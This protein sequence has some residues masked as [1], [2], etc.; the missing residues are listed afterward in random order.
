[1]E[2]MPGDVEVSVVITRMFKRM[3]E[4]FAAA[5][6]RGQAAGEI[7]GDYDAQAIGRL[8]VCTIQGLRVLGKTGP[9]ERDM[10]EL[11]DVALRTMA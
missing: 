6:A 7:P 2:M 1:M 4:L 3:Q 11:V 9:S 8:L 5:V 10:A